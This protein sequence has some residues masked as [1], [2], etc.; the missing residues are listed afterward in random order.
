MNYLLQLV[1][2]R[3]RKL[4]IQLTSNS[5]CLYHTLLEFSNEIGFPDS[6]T[7]T[8]TSLQLKSSLSKN[9]LR[10][11]RDQPAEDVSSSE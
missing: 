10:Q 3:K 7:A 5:I 1:E 6:F 8:N 4:C 9:K 11:A 2:F